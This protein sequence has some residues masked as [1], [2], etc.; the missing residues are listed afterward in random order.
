MDFIERVFNVDRETVRFTITSLL[1]GVALALLL[2]L[3][4]GSTSETQAT[5][6]GSPFANITN[7]VD[8][9]VATAS[10]D[11]KLEN[12]DET[13]PISSYKS[14]HDNSV[15][16]LTGYSVN[17]IND[18]NI[19]K[20]PKAK[21]ALFV[22]EE[23]PVIIDEQSMSYQP[24]TPNINK[25]EYLD[26]FI[27]RSFVAPGQDLI[28]HDLGTKKSFNIVRL[29][30]RLHMDVEPKTSADTQIMKN[31]YGGQWSWNRRPVIVEMNTFEGKR[32]IAGSM[33]GMPHGSGNIRNNNF[34]GNIMGFPNDGH[35][36]IHFK[37]SRTHSGNAICNQHQLNV[38]TAAGL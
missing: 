37:N 11:K 5:M 10:I 19:I 12:V 16:D 22:P 15:L 27:V 25:G 35:F 9:T 6:G 8:M 38:R 29:G 1:S 36:C 3:F 7:S 26:W 28:V 18:D 4:L 34:Y 32:F 24:L 31:I 14:Y 21:E 2:A 20:I 33:N 17:T 23:D 30:G 13:I